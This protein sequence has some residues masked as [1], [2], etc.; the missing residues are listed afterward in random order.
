MIIGRPSLKETP[1]E[2][3]VEAGV[4]V[5]RPDAVYPATLWFGFPTRFGRFVSG[6]ADGFI[7]GLLPLA[8]R[9][10]EDVTIHGDL[11]YRLADGLRDYQRFQATWKPA[12]FGAVGVRS[13]DLQ[14]RDPA[15]SDG[16]VGTAFSGGVDS[17]HTLWTHSA[18]NE[19]FPPA[20]I[21]HCLMINGFDSDADLAGTGRFQRMQRLY[22]TQLEKLGID[23]VVVRTNLLE[24]IG[25]ATLKQSFAAFVTAPA[26]QLGS[27]FSRYYV[28]SSYKFTHLGRFP[29]G[30]HPMFDHLLATE[31]M[32]TVHDGGH[33]TRVAKTVAISEWPATFDLL[34]VC[35]N[36]TGVQRDGRAIANCCTCDKCI[37]TMA[38]LDVAGAL[39]SYRC[40]P[41][42]LTRRNIRRMDY[43]TLGTRVFALE[44]I[45]FAKQ[46]GRKDVARD[47][48]QAIARSV[49]YRSWLHE[50]ILANHRLELR[51][52]RW[53]SLV[54]R[55]KRFIQ[56]LGLGRG[57]L[58][59]AAT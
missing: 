46:E 21:T 20:R 56:R 47:L 3:T 14:R 33:L 26:L 7:A 2:V 34:R 15:K 6:S 39:A 52:P 18:D 28:P 45:E 22:E 29:D 27:L 43:G 59:S 1:G 23:L 9:L 41:R 51:S 40:F 38:T 35:V 54:R 11:S 37:R 42:P 57:W 53:A 10:R 36:A 8:M 5:E 17:F 4:E 25:L 13:D 32:Q 19:R 55:P 31:S 58:Y 24:F 49:L 44:I 16:A 12:T 50:L 30:S 48:R